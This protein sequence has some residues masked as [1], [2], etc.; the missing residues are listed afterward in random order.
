[1]RSQ[2]LQH[3]QDLKQDLSHRV[4]LR[5]TNSMVTEFSNG[6]QEKSIVVNQKII[7]KRASDSID[8]LIKMN[9]MECGKKT[10]DLEWLF[11]RKQRR[12]ESKGRFGNKIRKLE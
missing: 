7:K 8:I 5:M 11:G 4:S 1:M 12:E 6:N 3:S 2:A 10:R 9:M